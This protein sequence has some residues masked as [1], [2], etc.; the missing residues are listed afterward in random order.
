MT[1]SQPQIPSQS[2]SGRTA[3]R[4]PFYKKF[5]FWLLIVLVSVGTSQQGTQDKTST[6]TKPRSTS[7]VVR[8]TSSPTPESRLSPD[9]YADILKLGLEG[10]NWSEAY[11]KLN[12]ARIKANAYTVDTA[13][14][15]S[16]W[17]KSNWT[18]QAVTDSE[19]V[20]HIMLTHMSEEERSMLNKLEYA[21]TDL[22]LKVSDARAL[23]DS[24]TG[25]V[26]DESTRDNL[27]GEISRASSLDSNDPQ[28]YEDEVTSLQTAMNAVN[29]SSYQKTLADLESSEAPSASP[30]QDQNVYYANCTAVR[31]A[32]KAP[33]YSGE[34]GYRYQLDRDN[35]GIACE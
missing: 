35:D 22:S 25:D 34:P 11:Q 18:V 8:S 6:G 16:V 30:E 32:G 31:A 4:K 1:N 10:M 20:A 29:A 23:L 12:D 3:K 28:R 14:G 17:M 26:A 21:K 2:T 19:G 5:W 27:N 33:L 15:K 9:R 13:D 7:S 24:S